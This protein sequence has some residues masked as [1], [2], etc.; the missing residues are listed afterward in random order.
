MEAILISAGIMVFTELLKRIHKK[1]QGTCWDWWIPHIL[2]FALALLVV[3]IMRVAPQEFI[4]D[5]V[6]IF[7]QAVA[8]YELFWKRVVQPAI[9]NNKNS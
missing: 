5:V 6:M 9:N 3:V 8:M 1:F 7:S 4:Q 2:V